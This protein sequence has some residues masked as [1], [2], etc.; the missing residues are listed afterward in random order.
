MRKG[1]EEL[2]SRGRNLNPRPADFSA[3][4]MLLDSRAL[5]LTIPYGFAWYLASFVQR[6][7]TAFWAE[8]L[9]LAQF[10]SGTVTRS[11]LSLK[12]LSGLIQN[13]KDYG[14]K[15]TGSTF[16]LGETSKELG[17]H[18]QRAAGADFAL[19]LRNRCRMAGIFSNS[20]DLSRK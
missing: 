19:F 13:R 11:C 8:P 4:I 20:A 17:C 5:F 9:K 16:G 14:A 12:W 1:I 18:P 2:W 6:L 15:R 7:F 10:C 3:D